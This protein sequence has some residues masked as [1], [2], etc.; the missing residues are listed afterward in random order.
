MSARTLYDGLGLASTG[1]TTREGVWKHAA[2]KRDIHRHSDSA[3]NVV[4]AREN[5]QRKCDTTTLPGEKS[6]SY[7]QE[8]L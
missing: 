7:H 5:R 3:D 6:S 2:G 8:Q 4:E 1:S